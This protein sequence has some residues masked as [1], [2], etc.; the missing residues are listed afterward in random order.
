M[1]LIG[2]VV[3]DG[4]CWLRPAHERP[5][6]SDDG[7]PALA[8]PLYF[9]ASH[10][11]VNGGRECRARRQ[12][13]FCRAAT[14]PPRAAREDPMTTSF[15]ISRIATLTL[16]L[17]ATGMVNAAYA[18]DSF[19]AYMANQPA[20]AVR[21]PLSEPKATANQQSTP[22]G[23]NDFGAASSAPHSASTTAGVSRVVSTK[24]MVGQSDRVGVPGSPQ[25]NLVREIYLP[26]SRPAG[27]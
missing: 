11:T 9:R 2:S 7:S 5:R 15:R 19:G 24:P 18:D 25:N 16:A 27:W 14:T 6:S 3:S 22:G 8:G 20:M 10:A 12:G 17:G 1:S 26:G 23:N 13:H 4:S 21:A